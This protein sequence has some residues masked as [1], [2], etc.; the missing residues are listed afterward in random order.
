MASALT[1][2]SFTRLLT[3][4]DSDPERAGE[5]YEDLRRTLIRFFEWRGAPFPEDHTDETFNR[6]ARKLCEGIE[7]KNIS[8][9]SY[10]VGRLVYLETLKGKDSKREP[11]QTDLA[12]KSQTDIEHR[13]DLEKRLLCLEQCLDNLPV[14]SRTLIVEYY[15]EDKR[16]RIERRK[17]L[18]EELGLQREALANRAQRLRDK[19][20]RCVTI[21]SNKKSAI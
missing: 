18:A 7:I 11:L 20:E 14:E 5:K 19:L 4:L 10:E 12:D 21:C 17:V 9:Y 16:D 3:S 15:Q 1:S 6:I 2:A 13:L 8:A